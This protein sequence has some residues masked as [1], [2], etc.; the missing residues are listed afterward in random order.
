MRPNI[1]L[2]QICSKSTNSSLNVVRR[3]TANEFGSPTHYELVTISKTFKNNPP[4][5]TTNGIYADEDT[6]ISVPIEVFDLEG[7]ALMFE[8]SGSPQHATCSISS[9]GLLNCTLDTDFYGNDQITINVTEVGIS[10]YDE[11]NSV[12]KVIPLYIS[13]VADPVERFFVVP[14]GEVFYE[15]RPSMRQTFRTDANMSTTFVAGTIALGCIDDGEIFT[16]DDVIRFTALGD[17]TYAIDE[18][19]MSDILANN[20][21][22]SQYRTVRAYRVTFTYSALESGLMTLYFIAVRGDGTYTP[23]I[24][25]N[26]YILKNPCTYGTCS[27]KTHGVAGCD[28]LARATSYEDFLCICAIGFTGEWCET[29]INECAPEPCG[30]L[31]DCEDLINDY[32]CVINVPK[33]L[34]IVICSLLLVAGMTFLTIRLIKKYKKKREDGGQ[35]R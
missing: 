34:A 8:I 21:T 13:A 22:L 32:A 35:R 1:L 29:E 17:S 5:I 27:H 23:S 31:Y 11:S 19:P 6:F 18:I 10:Q 9:T 20:L 25:V 24:T 12:E 4:N 16:Y 3:S 28:S 33:V 15:T 7:D 30:T 2:L 26:L 14:S